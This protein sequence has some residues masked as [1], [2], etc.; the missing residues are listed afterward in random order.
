MDM[1]IRGK[2]IHRG[3]PAGRAPDDRRFYA[4]EG[5]PGT[6]LKLS[7]LQLHAV[8]RCTLACAG[9]SSRS[10]AA[11][12][13]IADPAEVFRDLSALNTAAS[14]TFLRVTGGE[15]LL[16]PDLA[17][18]LKAARRS[19][20]ASCIQL[21]TNGTLL[22]KRPLDWVEHVDLVQVSHYPGCPLSAG[23][24]EKLKRL[25]SSK[26]KGLNVRDYRSFRLYQPVKSLSA[27]ES[28][29]V[30]ETCQDAHA[31]D[32]HPVSKGR[33]YL[34]PMSLAYG[35]GTESCALEP[36]KGLTERLAALLYRREP[37]EVCSNCL[38][39]SGNLVPHRQAPPAQ[40]AKASGRGFIDRSRLARVRND[41]WA[42][43]EGLYSDVVDLPWKDWTPGTSEGYADWKTFFAAGRRAKRK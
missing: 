4:L 7:A 26:G 8:S 18:L 40:W 14:C 43:D 24:L 36:L 39:T 38:G 41:P 17:G 6:R 25:C 23:A 35:G 11:P 30:F 32:C 15:P 21:L 10:P 29:D 20:I 42:E 13:E 3:P 31:C 19:G 16:H 12:A 9:C 37:L 27:V 5:R 22:D 33:V 34:C 1:K 2:K 28:A